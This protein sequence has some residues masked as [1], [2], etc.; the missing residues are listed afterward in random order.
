M[1]RLIIKQH[2]PLHFLLV[3]VVLCLIISFS[4]W[5][6]LD[7][8][9]WLYIQSQ[10]KE[11]QEGKALWNINRKLE[12]KNKSLRE[13]LIKLERMIQVENLTAADL[14]DDIKKLQSEVYDLKGELEFYRGIMVSAREVK[15]LNVQGL[16]IAA[17][18]Q[19]Q[20]YKF[21]LVLTH[22]TK[23]DSIAEGKVDM[24]L[25]GVQ[26]EMPETLKIKDVIMD[27]SLNLEYKFKHFK[28][29]EGNMIL[30]KGFVPYRV[31]VRLQPKDKNSTRIERVFNWIEVSI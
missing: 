5:M 10:F 22:V 31:T 13:R 14:Q 4:S 2:K 8:H 21:K 28:R 19:E 20:N 7:R 30:P 1:A 29:I 9:H 25:E 6:F 24:V 16:H 11:S 23:N 27:E 3:V 17:L 26:G 12:T 18:A 15:G